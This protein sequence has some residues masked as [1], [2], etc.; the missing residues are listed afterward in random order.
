MGFIVDK[1]PFPGGSVSARVFCVR[2]DNPSAMTYTGTDTWVLAEAESPECIVI[3]PAPSGQHV[4]DVLEACLEQGLR[5]GAVV[6]THVHADHTEGAE[7]LA[8]MTG[9]RVYAPFD[10]TLQ[11]G[12]FQPIERGPALRVVPLPGHSSDSVGLVYPADRSMFVGDVVF[13]HGPTVVYYPDGN[14]ADYMR[15]LDTIERIVREEDVRVLYPGHG[16]PITEPLIALE[17]TRAHRIERLKQIED[18][19]VIGV[20]RDADA[21]VDAVYTDIDPALRDAALRSVKAQLLYL[22]ERDK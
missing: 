11:P 20:E 15:S 3:D 22:D 18:A 17:A 16:Y 2:A 19:L 6:C 5:V 13:K 4:Q 8:D 7:E 21:L 12:H 9:T 14:L 10:G 1:E